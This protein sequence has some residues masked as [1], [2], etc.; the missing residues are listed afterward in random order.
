MLAMQRQKT[1]LKREEEKRVMVIPIKDELVG[2]ALEIS[3]MLR[4]ADMPVEVEVM[5][6]KVTK[7]LEDADRRE[8]DYAIIIGERELGEGAVVLRDLKKREQCIVK[9]ERIIETIKGQNVT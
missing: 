7:A 3:R 8:M 5:R 1:M 9:I 4:D 6:R 2:K